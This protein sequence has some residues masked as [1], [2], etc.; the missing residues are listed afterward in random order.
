MPPPYTPHAPHPSPHVPRPPHMHP[1]RLSPCPCSPPGRRVCLHCHKNYNIADIHL[2]AN[3]R[4]P[5][6]RLPPLSPP[7]EC[8]PHLEIR[9]DDTEEVVRARLEVRRARGGGVY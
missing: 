1:P 8:V 6:I 9:A 3:G 7:A 5:E 2:A 4:Q